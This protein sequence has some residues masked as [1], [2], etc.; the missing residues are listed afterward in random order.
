M[1]VSRAITCQQPAAVRLLCD[2]VPDSS[3]S[4]LS[5][6]FDDQRSQRGSTRIANVLSQ[7][8]PKRLADAICNALQLQA[9]PLA[10]LS[11]PARL[12][13]LQALKEFELPVTDS[14]GFAKAEVTTGGISLKEVDPRTMASRLA[15]GL[16]IAGEI[17]DLD[18]W[19]GGYNFQAAFSTGYIAGQAAAHSLQNGSGTNSLS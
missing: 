17:L 6:W 15:P 9:T 19:I 2:W 8:L 12:Q 10:E 4:Q 18:G 1:D 14:A 13:V 7:W 5:D 11:K 16:Y 3:A